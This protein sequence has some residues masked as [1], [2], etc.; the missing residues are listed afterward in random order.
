MYS[1]AWTMPATTTSFHASHSKNRTDK[2]VIPKT[3]PNQAKN[4]HANK[5]QAKNRATTIDHA[6]NHVT[7]AS[8]LAK[9]TR[10]CSTAH[11]YAGAQFIGYKWTELNVLLTQMSFEGF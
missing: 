7:A 9:Q 8:H 5:G 6:L 4:G 10:T 1:S 3:A 11:R 2:L